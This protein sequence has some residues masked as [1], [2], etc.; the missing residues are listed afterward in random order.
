M[1]F[2]LL[3]AHKWHPA[4]PPA[5]LDYVAWEL[6][7]IGK[8]SEII[9]M[10]FT[11]TEELE[12]L[13][14]KKEYEGICLTIRNLE[15]TMFSE[16]LHFPLPA[17][18]RLITALRNHTDSPLILGGSGFSIAPERI[19]EYLGA[20]YGITG[21]GEEALPLL[22]KYLTKKEGT[23]ADIPH[24]VYRCKGN[25]TRNPGFSYLRTL[26]AVKRGYVNY[27]LYFRP[28]HENFPGFGTIETKR[29]CPYQCVY[30]VEP[31]IKGRQVR[32]KPPEEVAREV[33]YFL[34][35]GVTHFFLADSEFNTDVNAAIDL[36]TFWKERDYHRTIKWIT[37]ATPSHFSGDLAELLP[38]SGNLCT[39]IDF[40]H[41]SDRMLSALGKEFKARDLE[42]VVTLCQETGVNFRGSLMLGGPGE[43]R[44]TVKGA[45][46]FFKGL[47]C[48]IFVVLGIRVFPNTPLGEKIQKEGPLAENPNLYGK[49][50]GNDDLFEPVYYISRELGEDIFDYILK[51]TG[52]SEQFYMATLPFNLTTKMCGPFRGTMPEYETAGTLNPQYLT[53]EKRGSPIFEEPEVV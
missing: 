30:C 36:C 9:D 11:D 43:D 32:V 6:E 35:E 39:M 38:Q 42:K 31:N 14:E 50:Y 21:G 41:A 47:S 15:K 40:G 26:P 49:V 44:E 4:S 1:T 34:S 37:Y 18:H 52:T 13:V 28:G 12:S 23:L 3:N 27:H 25:V 46:E 24:L 22:V 20:D 5:A 8:S 17:I 33:D 29:G 53:R 45:I 16:R 51:L 7:K 10:T 2:L 19:L 48:K